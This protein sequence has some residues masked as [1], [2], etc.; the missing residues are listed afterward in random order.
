[1]VH[2]RRQWELEIFNFIGLLE[3]LLRF[4]LSNLKAPLHNNL[5]DKVAVW[6]KLIS[7]LTLEVQKAE[8]PWQFRLCF[9]GRGATEFDSGQKGA[10]IPLRSYMAQAKKKE[11]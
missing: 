9:Q 8:L 5:F 6:Y 10:K 7:P 2:P 4:Q 1:M 3:F 11:A